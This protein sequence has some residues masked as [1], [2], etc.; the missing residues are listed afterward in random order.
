MRNGGKG[1]RGELILGE[2]GKG[3]KGDGHILV[4]FQIS[5]PFSF[6]PRLL[7]SQYQFPPFPSSPPLPP[8]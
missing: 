4:V 5:K 6:S 3:R 1:E 7:F 2:K 8:E